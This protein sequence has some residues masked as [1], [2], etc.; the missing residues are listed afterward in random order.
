VLGQLPFIAAN[1]ISYI[2]ARIKNNGP[3]VAKNVRYHFITESIR[4]PQTASIEKEA[5][6]ALWA[7]LNALVS[8]T[9]PFSLDPGDGR[10]KPLRFMTEAA[11]AQHINDGTYRFYFMAR[12]TW[13]DSAG[14][15]ETEKC[16]SLQTPSNDP[17]PVWHPCGS[18]NFTE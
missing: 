3:E 7:P 1:R 4:T 5:M 14:T 8:A 12:A 15:H 18:H 10:R 11:P 2:E 17:R 13:E 9:E 6:D 16:L